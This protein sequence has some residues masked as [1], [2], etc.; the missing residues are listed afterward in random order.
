M[1]NKHPN[2]LC[3]RYPLFLFRRLLLLGSMIEAEKSQKTLREPVCLCN[4]QRRRTEKR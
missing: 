2:E 1:Y 3:D 4:S